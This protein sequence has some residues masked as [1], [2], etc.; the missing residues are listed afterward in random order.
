MSFYLPFG[1][2]VVGTT[3]TTKTTALKLEKILWQV[4]YHR[5]AL[6][7][8]GVPSRVLIQ[9]PTMLARATIIA[10]SYEQ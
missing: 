7:C 3:G 1:E 4:H 9:L 10:T 8:T 5:S 6:C 2:V